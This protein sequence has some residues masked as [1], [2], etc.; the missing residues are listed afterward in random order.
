MTNYICWDR[1]THQLNQSIQQMWEKQLWKKTTISNDT[2][3]R[4][5]YCFISISS[6][7][8]NWAI[9]SDATYHMC[10]PQI[11]FSNIKP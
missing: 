11:K 3:G 4:N 1:T 8:S 7:I 5:S 10:D 6:D 9:D 2:T